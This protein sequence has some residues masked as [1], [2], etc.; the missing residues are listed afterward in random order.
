MYVNG[1]AS[2][3]TVEAA[4]MFVEELVVG[5]DSDIVGAVDMMHHQFAILLLQCQSKIIYNEKSLATGEH[6]ATDKGEPK[7]TGYVRWF[8]VVED[9]KEDL[10]ICYELMIG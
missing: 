5:I 3:E 4:S 8:K 7:A 10:R 1:E 9:S 2:T 6:K